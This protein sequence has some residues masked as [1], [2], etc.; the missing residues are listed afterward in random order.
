MASTTI[1]LASSVSARMPLSSP[2][3]CDLAKVMLEA[4]LSD[5]VGSPKNSTADFCKH[6]DPGRA[7]SVCPSVGAV[8]IGSP[9]HP[10]HPTTDGSG[11]LP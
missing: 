4:L 9:I 5:A 3:H 6:F 11:I 10:T 8:T 1:V 7:R 2:S